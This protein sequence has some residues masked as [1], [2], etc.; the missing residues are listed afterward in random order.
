[1]IRFKD[2]DSIGFHKKMILTE[3]NDR[4]FVGI[5]MS[6]LEVD[7]KKSFMTFHISSNDGGFM[8]IAGTNNDST[9]ELMRLTGEGDLHIKGGFYTSNSIF[10]M[11]SNSKLL[12]SDIRVK[13]NVSEA[14]LDICTDII[15][16][17]KLKRF[18]WDPD[19]FPQTKDRNV[20]GWIA[21]EIET[22]LP[23]S[24]YTIEKHGFSDF[25]TIDLHQINAA[26][27]GAL[28][29]A[30]EEINILKQRVARH[31]TLI[32]SL[33]SLSNSNDLQPHH[34]LYDHI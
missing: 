22:V 23:K 14:N 18:T 32:A 9:Q 5:G 24:V 21:Q 31:G 7:S 29:K 2:S 19:Y 20:I 16:N 11:N 4:M 28:Q 15:Q 12:D 34:S 6:N 13:K 10:S 26:M 8:F 17:L 25:R 33:I 1:M 3:S 27:F 30:L